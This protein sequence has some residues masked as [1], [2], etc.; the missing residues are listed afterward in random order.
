[1]ME[2]H[3]IEKTVFI[4]KE[5]KRIENKEKAKLEEVK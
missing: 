5:K 3:E 1:M 2:N 4:E